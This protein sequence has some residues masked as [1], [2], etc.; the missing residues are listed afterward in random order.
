MHLLW[1]ILIG[2]LTGLVARVVMPGTQSAG[3]I[4]TTAIGIIG[5]L[6]ATYVGIALHWYRP[7][8]SAGFVASVAG[9]VVLLLTYGLITHR[10]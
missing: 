10:R 5:S 8:Q 6:V 2:F 3:L 7:G 9:A 4:L 1:T